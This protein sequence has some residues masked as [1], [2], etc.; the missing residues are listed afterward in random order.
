MLLVGFALVP[1]QRFYALVE[2]ALRETGFTDVVK[3]TRENDVLRFRAGQVHPFREYAREDGDA[4]RVVVNVGGEMID[5]EQVV[6]DAA[7]LRHR[8]DGFFDDLLG[9]LDRGLA[10]A[11]HL[12][13]NRARFVE[14]VLVLGNESA[15]VVKERR[16][17]LE[18]L[19]EFVLVL[20]IDR[21]YIEKGKPCDVRFGE[22]RS[23]GK[24]NH[25][26]VVDNG[27]GEDHTGL[28][29]FH[30]NGLQGNSSFEGVV[31]P[32]SGSIIS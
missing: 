16:Y 4:H 31:S 24:D 27:T 11:F 21:R 15:S 22:E 20:D 19:A 29:L 14:N 25:H 10:A 13:E 2:Q 9:F 5:F 12:F 28:K 18:S 32:I 3:E 30:G 8:C 1:G 23:L 6:H 26:L 7:L 17:V